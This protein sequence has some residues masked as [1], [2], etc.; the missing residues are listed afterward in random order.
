MGEVAVMRNARNPQA[1]PSQPSSESATSPADAGNGADVPASSDDAADD[2][3]VA[4]PRALV[5]RLDLQGLPPPHSYHLWA[6]LSR[7]TVDFARRG[8][9]AVGLKTFAWPSPEAEDEHR[10]PTPAAPRQVCA[11]CLGEFE[12]GCTAAAPVRCGHAFHA[13]CLGPWMLSQA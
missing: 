7:W 2:D 5:P 6:I 12:P 4:R 8:A 9:N 11:I 10:E 3:E 1:F 13:L